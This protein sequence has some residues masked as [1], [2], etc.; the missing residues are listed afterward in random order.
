M[1]RARISYQ[2]QQVIF[3]NMSDRKYQTSRS[4]LNILADFNNSLVWMASILLLVFNSARL[5][6]EFLRIVSRTLTTISI[7]VTLIF[8]SSLARSRYLAIFSFSFIFPSMVCWNSEIYEMSRW[9]ESQNSFKKLIL[10]G[11]WWKKFLV[12]SQLGLKFSANI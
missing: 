4:L 7:P 12:R 10:S 5:F 11:V 6:S 9:K 2:F 3:Y 8:W 1:L